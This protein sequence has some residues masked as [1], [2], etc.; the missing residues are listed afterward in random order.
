MKIETP[1]LSSR[2]KGKLALLDNCII[3]F[4]VCRRLPDAQARA[5]CRNSPSRTL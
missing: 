1:I 4:F 3:H 2:S 5:P